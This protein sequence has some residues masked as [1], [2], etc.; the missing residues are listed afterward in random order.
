MLCAADEEIKPVPT[1]NTRVHFNEF[2]TKRAK[3][4][5]T[6]NSIWWMYVCERVCLW[7]CVNVC[8]KEKPKYYDYVRGVWS[9]IVWRSCALTFRSKPK[10][11]SWM[12]SIYCL[13]R[14]RTQLGDNY[15]SAR[16]WF[17]C[18][19]CSAR[20]R[21]CWSSLVC[22]SYSLI[23]EWSPLRFGTENSQKINGKNYMVF[24]LYFN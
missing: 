20:S 5:S 22:D 3:T 12:D 17:A 10:I 7:A 21:K 2:R 23:W 19:C 18:H 4:L 13:C 24:A 9:M 15:Y 14:L 6:S 8:R 16:V 1:F 11:L